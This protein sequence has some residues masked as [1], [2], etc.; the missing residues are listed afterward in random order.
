MK[1]PLLYLIV[2]IFLS[3][4]SFGQSITTNYFGGEL[5]VGKK[6]DVSFTT[7][8]TF[9]ANNKFSVQLNYT[10]YINGNPKE[11]FLDLE[12][13][14]TKSPLQVT[15]PDTIRS[16][17]YFRLRVNSSAPAIEG[18]LTSYIYFRF[19]LSIEIDGTRIINPNDYT[20][21]SGRVIQGYTPAKVYLS[22]S[23]VLNITSSY[24][25][26]NFSRSP[27]TT[28]TYS[29]VRTENE[30]GV[31]YPKT[32]NSVTL[33]VN[34]VGFKLIKYDAL[35]PCA[36]GKVL[37]TYDSEKPFEKDNTFY[38]MLTYIEK[39]NVYN[40]MKINCE[41]VD[42][43]TLSFI[44][45]KSLGEQ[46]VNIQYY[47]LFSTSPKA[48]AISQNGR[49]YFPLSFSNPNFVIDKKKFD[50]SWGETADLLITK[51]NGDPFSG[52]IYLF[53]GKKNYYPSTSYSSDV[54]YNFK[55]SPEV[56][57]QYQVIAKIGACDQ[58]SQTIS[59]IDVAVNN[60]IQISKT[61]KIVCEGTQQTI[62]FKKMGTFN[63]NNA[64][65]VEYIYYSNNGLQ[66]VLL[67]STMLNDSTIQYTLPSSYFST[68]F[69]YEN[70]DNATIRVRSSSPFVVSPDILVSVRRLPI[71]SLPSGYSYN[72]TTGGDYAYIQNKISGGAPYKILVNDGIKDFTVSNLVLYPAQNTVYTIKEVSNVCGTVSVGNPKV[73]LTIKNPVVQSLQTFELP[74]AEPT[75]RK[76]YC[77]GSTIQ[78]PFIIN[79]KTDTSDR[80]QF[81]IRMVENNQ[82]IWKSIG[83]GKTSPLTITI[84]NDLKYL[85]YYYRIYNSTKK[86][87]S[88]EAYLNL[89]YKPS[90]KVMTDVTPLEVIK[91]NSGGVSFSLLG[92]GNIAV[93]L[94]NGIKAN[95][96]R[97]YDDQPGYITF[98]PTKTDTYSIK[99]ISNEC[100][101]GTADG[102]YT[103]TAKDFRINTTRYYNNYHYTCEGQTIGLSKTINGTLPKDAKL[104][105][106]MSDVE[107]KNFS[108]ITSYQ[109]GDEIYGIIPAGASGGVYTR[110][111]FK[112]V[113]TNYDG[114]YTPTDFVGLA[115]KATAKLTGEKGESMLN[116]VDATA[117]LKIE[118]TG[119]N[120]YYFNLNQ[121]FD[122]ADNL[123]NEYFQ[124]GGT[125]NNPY[126]LTIRPKS[127]GEIYELTNLSN[128]CGYGT[129]SG[130]VEIG[131]IKPTLV[132]AALNNNNICVGKEIEINFTAAGDYDANNIY[133]VEL[134]ASNGTIY[135]ILQTKDKGG[136]KKIQIP[137]TLQGGSYTL[138]LSSTSPVVS[139]IYTP[140]FTI[141]PAPKVTLS[142][143]AS[144]ILGEKAFIS[145]K[146]DNGYS[147]NYT[148][149][150]GSQGQV[151]YFN[152]GNRFLVSVAPLKT[153]E[154]KLTSV[155]NSCGEGT[156][157]G[158]AI[159]EVLPASAN[160][161]TI[162][163]IRTANN[164]AFCTG[165]QL[166]VSYTTK[167]TFSASNKFTVQIS[168]ENGLN[169]KNLVTSG[170]NP[171]TA[172]LP[173]DLV[174]SENYRFKIVASDKDVSASSSNL[175]YRIYRGTTAQLKTNSLIL[176]PNQVGQAK[177]SLSS[178]PYK[179]VYFGTDSLNT[180][181]IFTNDTTL[182]VEVKFVKN[183]TVYKLFSVIDAN[184]GIGKIVGNNRLS[185]ELITA[186][187]NPMPEF[188]IFPNPATNIISIGNLG[189]GKKQVS[190]TNILGKEIIK[191]T[192]IPI[193]DSNYQL[194]LESLQ[195]GM[196]LLIIQQNNQKF[197]YKI[198][199]E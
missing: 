194:N 67:P 118:F 124:T 58:Y 199:K 174:N 147:F 113:C 110:R 55:L 71:F 196:Y 31:E 143:N 185:I 70:E 88:N 97:N 112:I 93:E 171:L 15:I 1:K 125:N 29:V 173:A 64:F 111:K 13:T 52:E 142:G 176:M 126:F 63:A 138:K 25:N 186:N 163:S 116:Q 39:N 183:P 102:S 45:P 144:I 89:A 101:N 180:N 154:Y 47:D 46:Y 43:N 165:K 131:S 170:T 122:L 95:F 178:N 155:S 17:P 91:G 121:K 159:I 148:L 104:V 78:V 145:L 168:D 172:E 133:K 139:A 54:Y 115:T 108:D 62:T 69:A 41:T 141:F 169:Y 49:G 120:T 191:E 188:N 56:S 7:T 11:Y 96:Y 33:S 59:T 28:T 30:C 157:I 181:P 50:I 149:S 167:G 35:T 73:N 166:L 32:K 83:T 197:T 9:A 10:R 177:I 72:Y 140:N 128:A 75:T 192:Q 37:L 100:G 130:K 119:N 92:G 5:C 60:G 57:T 98:I 76:H 86:I 16:V 51:K 103:I 182:T 137:N 193:S 198:F 20:L 162:S 87:A 84:P 150:D 80:Y 38:V 160:A 152:D 18:S 6:I 106:Q 79:G 65:A 132:L 36:G 24:S 175:L 146:D 129:V 77:V 27:S 123:N 26:F 184:C 23:S 127:K 94:S 189:I 134:I 190:V 151:S 42:K 81:E 99:S 187:E 44:I 66:K 135:E 61:P 2:F 3:I 12:T 153:T 21:I 22:D 114:F 90:G 179:Y 195:S 158:K 8:G 136:I 82:F 117:K 107:G 48:Q 19:P 40:T 4:T 68:D 156:A 14:S 74:Q 34:P 109:V 161:V 164:T 105:I 53:D 85:Q